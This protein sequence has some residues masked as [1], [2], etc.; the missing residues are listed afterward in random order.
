M[1]ETY[2]LQYNSIYILYVPR[3]VTKEEYTMITPNQEPQDTFEM[4]K[5]LR[6][7]RR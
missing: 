3:N 2:I 4:I 7:I 5:S 1:V 6:W